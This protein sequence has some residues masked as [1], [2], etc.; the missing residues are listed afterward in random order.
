ML[1]LEEGDQENS[2]TYTYLQHENMETVLDWINLILYTKFN[3][4]QEK[5]KNFSKEELANMLNC[6][7]NLPPFVNSQCFQSI[8]FHQFVSV[9]VKESY[10][11]AATPGLIY[12]SLSEARIACF[13][14]HL[15]EKP[16]FHLTVSKALK[17]SGT[18]TLYLYRLAFYTI[19][20]SQTC[21]WFY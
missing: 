15:D 18:V 8:S 10:T 4:L 6:G 21:S 11:S 19:V 13:K 12:V 9:I 16:L 3:L 2:I 1:N 14:H 7:K 5:H 17:L 20:F